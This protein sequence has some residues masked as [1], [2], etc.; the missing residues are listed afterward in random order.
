MASYPQP[1]DEGDHSKREAADI[2]GILD[3]GRATFALLVG[4]GSE[5]LLGEVATARGI[6]VASVGQV[7]T[8][9]HPN[10]WMEPEPVLRGCRALRD[11]EVLFSPEILVDPLRL[12]RSMAKRNSLVAVWPGTIVDR[13]ATFSEQGRRDHYEATL[14]FDALVIRTSAATF[15]DQAPFEVERAR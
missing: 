15:P 6:Q 3:S 8:I 9:D 13:Q 1:M 11:L 7:V 4:D 14:S 12:L 5:H 10:G 2:W